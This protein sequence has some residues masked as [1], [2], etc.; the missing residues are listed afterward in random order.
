LLGKE[1]QAM[2]SNQE[3]LEIFNLKKKELEE[4]GELWRM[5]VSEDEFIVE[6]EKI[7]RYGIEAR[8]NSKLNEYHIQR[9]EEAQVY[10]LLMEKSTKEEMIEQANL[11]SKQAEEEHKQEIESI[12]SSLEKLQTPL[13]FRDIINIYRWIFRKQISIEML[14]DNVRDEFVK[15]KHYEMLN[16]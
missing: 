10:V 4:R 16:I 1:I 15:T 2:K 7:R 13:K 12:L 6:I 5:R 3:Y 9:S 8:K 11:I 14:P